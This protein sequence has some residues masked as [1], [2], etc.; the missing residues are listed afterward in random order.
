MP[1]NVTKKW[2][3]GENANAGISGVGSGAPSLGSGSTISSG[4]TFPAGHTIKTYYD[5]VTTS[6]TTYAADTWHNIMSVTTSVPASTSSN[7]IIQWMIN[8][9][10]DDWGA[11]S[12]C[13][14]TT[15]STAIGVNTDSS[16]GSRVATTSGG[17]N[18]SGGNATS[19]MIN[20]IG[21]VRQLGCTLEA[22]TFKV[23][24]YSGRD[25]IVLNRHWANND[26]DIT[27]NRGI[28]S[29]LVQEIAG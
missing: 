13:Y 21:L 22:Q 26:D 11:W 19:R 1:T 6:G 8:Y 17:Q 4:A 12:R 9:G 18:E 25:T 14:N 24:L 2:L 7:F 15:T 23:Q 5:E 29:M 20:M 16:M 27:G 3:L 10:S 28:C